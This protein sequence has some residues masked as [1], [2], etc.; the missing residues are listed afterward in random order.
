[1]RGAINVL[2]M[3]MVC[4]ISLSAIACSPANG[5]ISYERPN[6]RYIVYYYD[7]DNNS[8]MLGCNKFD[9]QGDRVHIHSYWL[10]IQPMYIHKGDSIEDQLAIAQLINSE[11]DSNTTYFVYCNGDIWLKP[12]GIKEIK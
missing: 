5:T 3:I 9:F 8:R 6:V 11:Q 7:Q 4:L 2:G 1:M 10:L 12:T